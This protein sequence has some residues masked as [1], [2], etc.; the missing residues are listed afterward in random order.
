MIADSVD[1]D[2]AKAG[3]IV[4]QLLTNAA[5]VRYGVITVSAKLHEGR[6]VEVSLSRTE[7]TRDWEIIKTKKD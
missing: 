7:Q 3:E 2:T 5:G 4:S 6:I 1:F